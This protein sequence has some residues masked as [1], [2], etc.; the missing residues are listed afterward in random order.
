MNGLL[1]ING[2]LFVIIYLLGAWMQNSNGVEV[3]WGL[4][5]LLALALLL[6]GFVVAIPMAITYDRYFGD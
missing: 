3:T 1:K 6:P 4:N 2:V 5:I